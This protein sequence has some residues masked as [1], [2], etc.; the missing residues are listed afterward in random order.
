MYHGGCRCFKCKL[1]HANAEKN[2][3]DRRSTGITERKKHVITAVRG[4]DNARAQRMLCLPS[5][6][7]NVL[8]SLQPNVG[9]IG[10]GT[11]EVP[12]QESLLAVR[13]RA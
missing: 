1:A 11:A 10:P 12:A 8:H 5:R 6:G 2:R 4:G 9:H 3:R 13:N 7:P